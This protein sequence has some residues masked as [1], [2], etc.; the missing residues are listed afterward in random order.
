MKVLLVSTGFM[1]IADSFKAA[2][3]RAGCQ[4]LY[5]N[6]SNINSDG[7]LMKS[8]VSVLTKRSQA[9]LTQ[10]DKFNPD[11][12]LDLLG[13]NLSAEALKVINCRAISIK[14]MLDLIENYKQIA[15]S[16]QHYNYIFTY[17]TYDIEYIKL[18]G[19]KRVELL[20]ATYDECK[21]HP[22]E[23]IKDIDISFVGQMF[24]SGQRKRR[25]LLEQLVSDF[26]DLKFAI[27]GVYVRPYQLARFLRWKV[28]DDGKCFKNHA[29][30]YKRVNE[31]YNRSKI[32][33]N[34]NSFQ[35]FETWSSRLLE[36]MGTG[37][38]VLTERTEKIESMLGNGVATYTSYEELKN[39]INKYINDDF[40][41]ARIAKIGFE[42]AHKYRMDDTV[43]QI[44]C[45]VKAKNR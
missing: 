18:L 4:C 42:I 38:F 36:M 33:L 1:E 6:T 13:A 3:E 9:V 2:F 29:I 35:T 7:S 44:L 12:V 11:L 10:F 15:N 43:K 30:D 14:Y 17:E 31:I 8:E 28:T 41:R 45:V 23:A 5:V 39:L 20:Y 32:C 40:E 25:R 27:Y 19:G 34:I 22:V 37:S 24:T 26:S 21:Y 16:I